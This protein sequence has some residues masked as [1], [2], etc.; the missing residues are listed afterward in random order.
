MVSC[1]AGGMVSVFFPL[2][3][4][5]LQQIITKTSTWKYFFSMPL[6]TVPTCTVLLLVGTMMFCTLHK[7][8]FTLHAQAR[9]EFIKLK[10]FSKSFLIV[11]SLK[12]DNTPKL[13]LDIVCL[14]LYRKGWNQIHQWHIKFLWVWFC[15]SRHVQLYKLLQ[16]LFG[17]FLMQNNM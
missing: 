9:V 12:L 10:W 5:L 17:Y 3:V 4:V 15:K 2:W 1:L 7:V 11:T 16:N 6:R 13:V 14:K 8:L